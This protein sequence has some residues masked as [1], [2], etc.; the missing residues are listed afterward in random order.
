M[1][2]LT[3]SEDND[4]LGT[5]VRDGKEPSQ[6]LNIAYW[7]NFANKGIGKY[8]IKDKDEEKQI[9]GSIVTPALNAA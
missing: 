1:D 7:R 2:D 3:V 5:S 9:S 6:S 8:Q 4:H